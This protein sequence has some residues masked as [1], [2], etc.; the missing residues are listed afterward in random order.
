M[1]VK[2]HYSWGKQGLGCSDVPP[3]YG[4]GVCLCWCEQVGDAHIIGVHTRCLQSPS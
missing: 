1:Q 2:N 4:P 3:K